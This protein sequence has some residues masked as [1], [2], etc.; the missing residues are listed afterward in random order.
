MYLVLERL[1]NKAMKLQNKLEEDD[2]TIVEE[3]SAFATSRKLVSFTVV[4]F[5]ADHFYWVCC[6][7]ILT[8]NSNSSQYCIQY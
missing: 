6:F 4:N 7:E 8:A 1:R 5:V 2:V 3:S